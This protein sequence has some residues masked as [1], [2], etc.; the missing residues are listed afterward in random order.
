MS[1]QYKVQHSTNYSYES[2]VSLSQQLLRLAPRASARQSVD[3]AT[4]LIEPSPMV[5]HTNTDYFGNHITRV[6][7]QEPHRR[8]SIQASST[9]TITPPEL[10]ALDL[11][12]AWETVLQAVRK[13]VTRDA[14][15][16]A[17]FCFPSPYVDIP[18]HIDELVADLFVP[19]RPMLQAVMALTSRIYT[20]FTYRGGV[21]DIWTP[22]D[23]VLNNRQG[24]CQ[25]FAHLQIAAL[26]SLG[27]PAKYISGYLLTHPAPGT[28][29]LVGSD[30]SHAWLSVWIP[31]LGWVDFDPTNNSMPTQE[32]ILLCWGRDYGDVSPIKGFIV[33]GGAHKLKVSVDVAPHTSR[34]AA[35][36]TVA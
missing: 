12:L 6:S 16:A 20:D 28:E 23:T 2:D 33:G 25:D 1:V 19:E 36:Q 30:E 3:G 5:R 22:V 31:G 8:L 34:A 27:L 17:G 21:T 29:R 15:I 4:I 13:P 9:I 11:S 24:V 7:L 14:G 26:R 32:H 35:T 18:S 10:P